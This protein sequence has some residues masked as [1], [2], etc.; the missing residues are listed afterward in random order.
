MAA[1]GSRR[2]LPADLNGAI[3]ELLADQRESLRADDARPQPPTPCSAAGL[4]PGGAWME[5]PIRSAPFRVRGFRPASSGLFG[6]ARAK[7]ARSTIRF[8]I[9]KGV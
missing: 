7:R 3:A 1:A 5:R 4:R 8:R 9:K 2:R 6:A